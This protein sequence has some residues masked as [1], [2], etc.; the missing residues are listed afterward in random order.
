M[1]VIKRTLWG[2]GI[3]ALLVS[4]IAGGAYYWTGRQGPAF[5]T[6]KVA[7]VTITEVPCPS[8][9]SG[10][11]RCG[12]I[13]A[14]LDYSGKD[15]GSIDVG[16]VFYRALLQ[17]GDGQTLLQ[18]I[19]GGPGQVMSDDMKP[20]P[21]RL[22]RW[23]FRNRPL[24]FIDP[25]GVGGISE[26]LNCP[27]K[28]A[29]DF[30]VN[31]SDI[32]AACA[33][34]IGARRIHYTS[35]NT[36]RDF[37]L[38]RRALGFTS[39]DLI[40]FSYGTA[41]A[42]MYAALQPNVVRTMT[43]DG[44]YQF[45]NYNNPY[46][47]TFYDGAMRQLRQICERAAGCKIENTIQ[48]L[49]SVVATLRTAPKP[50]KPTGTGWMIAPGKQLNPGAIIS[51]LTANGNITSDDDGTI[52][53][54]Y[55]LIGALYNAANGDWSLLEQIAALH[56]Q[57]NILPHSSENSK[58][59]SLANNITC[60][61]SSSVL[62]SAAQ[63]PDQRAAT[64]ETTIARYPDKARFGPF[65]PR[66]WSLNSFQSEYDECLKYPAPPTGRAIER[67]ESFVS[68]LPRTTPV[69]IMNGDLDQQTPHE[70]AMTAAAL[71]DKPFYARFKHFNHVIMPNSLCAMN[72][73]A[74]FMRTKAVANP[75]QCA[76]SDAAPYVID[77]IPMKDRK[78]NAKTA[79]NGFIR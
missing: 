42:P 43:L 40:S 41:L 15:A 63:N 46:F 52:K 36:V 27:L 30:E 9:I 59:V 16:F 21:M 51:L 1:I 47:T 33:E 34:K 78:P 2:L 20:S 17:E 18:F 38:V 74:D 24:L 13:K 56:L 58:T 31:M 73:V 50:I 62:W 8:D 64:F 29:Y 75:N 72:M 67:R 7:G 69:L 44:A 70:D 25:R 71:F 26:M 32:V 49:N 12:K 76:D 68:T 77:R 53:I 4:V 65:T 61:E 11:P 23:Q 57:K 37:D 14:P 6:S 28:T 55:P 22:M 19:D 54:F 5:E 45:T 35:A 3:V 79:E 60:Q 66:E 39:I 48:H 10:G